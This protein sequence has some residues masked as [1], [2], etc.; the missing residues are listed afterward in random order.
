M[1]AATACAILETGQFAGIKDSSGNTEIFDALH[2]LR[3]RMPFRLLLGNERLLASHRALADGVIS[4][5]ACGLV[6]KPKTKSGSVHASVE[7]G[8]VPVFERTA[9][10]AAKP[11]IANDT[12][13]VCHTID[14]A[15]SPLG[16]S[17]KAVLST[18]S[19]HCSSM[20]IGRAHV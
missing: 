19:R 13:Y 16:T 5:C 6:R 10:L 12:A 14:S 15:N 9:A 7:V 4:G 20:Q 17:A 1:E 11:A 8:S 3:Q 18:R 2:A